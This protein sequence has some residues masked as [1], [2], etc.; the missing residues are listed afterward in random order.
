MCEFFLYEFSPLYP[1]IINSA[2]SSLFSYR[3]NENWM[4]FFEPQFPAVFEP[5][6]ADS[7]AESRAHSIC[8]G[9]QFCLFDIAATGREDVGMSTQIGGQALEE[10]IEIS[11]PSK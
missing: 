4:T 1:G 11:A 5:S 9:D 8:N 6:F 2:E 7:E 10:I 3:T